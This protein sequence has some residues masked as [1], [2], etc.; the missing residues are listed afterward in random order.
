MGH[1]RRQATGRNDSNEL[2]TAPCGHT[3]A[4]RRACCD[5]NANQTGYW[6]S[7]RSYRAPRDYTVRNC[8]LV[9]ALVVLGAALG[10]HGD[11]N[12][13]KPARCE[14]Y[15][16]SPVGYAESFTSSFTRF[17]RRRRFR[18]WRADRS[19]KKLRRFSSASCMG[20]SR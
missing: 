14:L 2:G 19:L 10:S 16:T 5:S 12:E 11:H 8:G 20:S 13:V 6:N 1:G 4:I 18:A 3:F 9:P 17:C 15:A 7:G